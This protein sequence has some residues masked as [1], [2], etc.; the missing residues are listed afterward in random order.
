LRCIPSHHLPNRPP[1]TQQS[2]Q[3][4]RRKGQELQEQRS[5]DWQ[6]SSNT[7]AHGRCHTADA[8]P[9]RARGN[10]DAEDAAD[11][12]GHVERQTTAYDV[13]RNAPEGCAEAETDEQSGCREAYVG[14]RN[15]EFLGD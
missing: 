9:C 11:Q 12:E 3:I 13:R 5:I 8:N 6:I 14:R 4:G 15:A 2:K 10:A 7:Q 1:N